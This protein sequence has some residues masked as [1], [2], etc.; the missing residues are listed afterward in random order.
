MDTIWDEIRDL[1]F[2]YPD[3]AP[4]IRQLQ[5][6]GPQNFAE[7]IQ[8]VENTAKAQDLLDRLQVAKDL[9]EHGW[10]CHL[11]LNRNGTIS[12]RWNE[13]PYNK[14]LVGLDNAILQQYNLAGR[15]NDPYWDYD[16]HTDTWTAARDI[17]IGIQ[18]LR[19]IPTDS[20]DTEESSS[21]VSRRRLNF[22]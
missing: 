14:V 18:R 22:D 4:T 6:T 21:P 9:K 11:R 1:I 12:Y 20:D 16:D 15:F 7:L 8:L 10:N 5:P 17:N 2:D 13:A 19:D 3:L